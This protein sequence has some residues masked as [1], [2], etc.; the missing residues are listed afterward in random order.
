VS[1][2]LGDRVADL[3]DGRMK[4]ADAERAFAHV[5]ACTPCRLALAAQRA[6]SSRLASGSSLDAPDDLLS[7][8]RGIPAQPG[9]PVV[10]IPSQGGAGGRPTGGA[11]THPGGR[12]PESVRPA[13]RARRGRVALVAVAGAAALAVA[14]AV[15][16][17][18]ALTSSV[19]TRPAIA[20]VV[21][22]FAVEHATSAD[23]MPFSGP[24]L[25]LVGYSD[26]AS[27]ASSSPQP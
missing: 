12:G 17:S 25:A 11:G 3:A 19:V 1:R 4:P 23:Q 9:A 20:P 7:R 21:D 10:A 26:P 18:A 27:A 15:G 5:A 8:L 16:G 24:R 14:V 22:T 6:T 13:R 2:C